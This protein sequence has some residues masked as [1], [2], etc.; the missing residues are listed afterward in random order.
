[1]KGRRA[2]DDTATMVR[3]LRRRGL[4]LR[5]I[6]QRAKVSKTSVYRLTKGIPWEQNSVQRRYLELDRVRDE[7][8]EQAVRPISVLAPQVPR[9]RIETVSE[10]ESDIDQAEAY[11]MQNRNLSL[12][13]E[14]IDLQNRLDSLE[15]DD[16]L[17]EYKRRR[18]K[19]LSGIAVL[20]GFWSRRQSC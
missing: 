17:E 6:A 2:S 3:E 13:Y 18:K 20:N 12:I 9:A 16:P 15:S 5:K 11:L 14:I 8:A 10:D 19:S 4:S 1:M 7:R